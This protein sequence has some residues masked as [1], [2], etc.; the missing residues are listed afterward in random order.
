MPNTAETRREVRRLQ[1][2]MAAVDYAIL[3][4]FLV[5]GEFFNSLFNLR[6]DALGFGLAARVAEAFKPTVL[7]LFTAMFAIQYAFTHAALRPLY[8]FFESDGPAAPARRAAASLPWRM[9]II[10]TVGWTVGTTAYYALKGWNVDSGIPY[11]LGLAL[12]M[13]GGFIATVYA[14]IANNLLLIPFKTRLN[15]LD[16]QEGEDDLF[17]RIKEYSIALFSGLFL[18]SIYSYLI[19]YYANRPG[20]GLG[21][22][23]AWPLVGSGLFCLAAVC[24]ATVL[25]K[26]EYHTQIRFLKARIAELLS[27]EADATRRVKLLYFDEIGEFGALF[28]RF[29]DKFQV[30]VAGVK[31]SSATLEASMGE[32]SVSAKEVTTTSNQQA[33]A[34]KEVVS[35]MEDATAIAHGISTAVGEVVRIARHTRGNVESGVRLVEQNLAKMEDIRIKNVD[36][37]GGIRALIDKLQSIWEIVDI[38]N[39]IV[40]QTRIIAFNA[41]LEAST[42]GEAGKNFQIVAAEIKRLADSTT[43]STA[44]IQQRIGEIQKASNNL[45][46]VSEEGSEKVRQGCSISHEVGDVFQSILG[47]AEVSA[48]SSEKAA[49]SIRVQT[50]SFEQILLTMKEISSGIESFTVSARRT[51]TIVEDLRRLSADLGDGVRKYRTEDAA[52]DE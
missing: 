18:A 33:A 38:I 12:K 28:N 6:Y 42:A 15:I 16:I 26:H 50:Q 32:L 9:I 13:S 20:D 47:S 39:S 19:Y 43:E 5:A 22:E 44:E 4:A 52:H 2:T 49:G 34:V 3:A 8:A 41:S 1:I 31:A 37:I 35:T 23:L 11:V 51:M 48:S 27:D 29:L 17:L 21:A 46:I 24:G 30:M 36:T 40:D 10:Q 45:I 7:A 25:S 14:S